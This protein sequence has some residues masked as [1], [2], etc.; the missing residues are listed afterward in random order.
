MR[1]QRNAQIKTK[2]ET[3]TARVL[4]SFERYV[5]RAFFN[6]FQTTDAEGV[7]VETFG[8]HLKFLCANLNFSLLFIRIIVQQSLFE[9]LFFILRCFTVFFHLF[10][11]DCVRFVSGS[12]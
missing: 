2:I 7:T 6:C 5:A 9:S 11:S 3:F 10:V 4:F 1:V 8:P 12:F